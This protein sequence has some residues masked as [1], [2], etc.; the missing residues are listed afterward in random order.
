MNAM[1]KHKRTKSRNV[2]LKGQAKTAAA[3]AGATQ[4]FSSFDLQALISLSFF[5]SHIHHPDE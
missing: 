2:V 4:H 1:T 5:S 3:A